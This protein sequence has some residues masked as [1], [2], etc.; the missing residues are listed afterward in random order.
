MKNV[1]E[2]VDYLQGRGYKCGKSAVYAHVKRGLVVKRNGVFQERDVDKYAALY[3]TREFDGED[4]HGRDDLEQLQREKIAADAQKAKAQ[5]EH[6]EL[7]TK[8]ESGKYIDRDLFF[9]EMA[10]RAA[11]LKNDLEN[12][13]RSQAGAMVQTC[14]G[15]PVRVPDVIELLLKRLEVCLGR[16]AEEKV[17]TVPG[18]VKGEID[19]ES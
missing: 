10:A 19:D 16:Y 8:V 18:Q 9:G 3:L 17:W 14:H 4:G 1:L 2:M 13:I 12:M 5:A 15:E 11:I 6:W 7:K